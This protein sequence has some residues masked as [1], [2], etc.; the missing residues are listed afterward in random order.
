MK[1][2]VQLVPILVSAQLVAVEELVHGAE[3]P[4]AVSPLRPLT[5]ALLFVTPSP[6]HQLVKIKLW[7]IFWLC[8]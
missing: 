5:A 8:Y 3:P 4:I 7:R 1:N 2:M 6:T